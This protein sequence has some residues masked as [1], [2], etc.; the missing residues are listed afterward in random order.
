[1]IFCK[2]P[3]TGLCAEFIHTAFHATS[4]APEQ[5][6]VKTELVNQFGLFN[7]YYTKGHDDTSGAGKGAK[8][9]E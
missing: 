9:N 8:D 3:S 4:F 2:Q 1:M 6:P 7:K 5:L